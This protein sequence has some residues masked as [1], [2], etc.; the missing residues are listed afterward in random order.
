MRVPYSWLAEL[1]ELPQNIDDL[2]ARLTETGTEVE[3]LEKTGAEFDHIVT[4]KIVS[5]EKH[6]DSDHMWVTMVDLGQDEPVQIVCGAQNFEEGDHIVTAL[7]GAHLPGDIVIKKSKLRGVV[8][9]GMNCSAR[10]LGL[11]DDHDGIMILPE[12]A[13]IGLPFAQYAK[14]SDTI[15]VLEPTPNRPDM[16]SMYGTAR[17]VG[18]I[19]DKPFGIEARDLHESDELSTSDKVAVSIQDP[20][21]AYRYNARLITDV[22]VGPSPEWLQDKI[23][24][25][26][27]RPI[28]NVVDLTN[29]IMF[30]LGQPLHAFDFDTLAKNAQGKVEIEVRA[31]QD[32]EKFTT[33]DQVERKLTE[34]MTV[35]SDKVS[36]KAIALAG[37]MGGLNSEVSE[38][39]TAVLL[40]TAA[41]SSAYTSRTSRNLQ[42]FSEASMRF[43]RQVDPNQVSWIADYA[44]SLLAEISGGKIAKGAVEAVA[45]EFTMPKL[46]LRMDKLRSFVGAPISDEEG[47]KFLELL[48]C[49]VNHEASEASKYEV[50]PPSFRPDLEREIDLYEE[51]LR[52]WG[53]ERVESKLP[54][55]RNHAGGLDQ[56][57]KL[58][59]KIGQ[60]LRA[61]GLSE[62]IT[63]SLVDANDLVQLNMSEV[64]L[65]LAT[66]LLNPMS[67]EQSEMRRSL[68]P[69]LLRA[70]AYN[71][72]HGVSNVH[73]YEQGTLFFAEEGKKQ[74]KE[75][76]FVSAV[77]CGQWQDDTWMGKEDALG[78]YDAKGIVEVL[79]QELHL[80]K[81]KIA[82][83]DPDRY[84]HLQPGRIA[85]LISQGQVIGWLGEIH[86]RSLKNFEVKGPVAAFELN[87]EFLINKAVELVEYK[88]VPKLPAVEVDFAIVVDEAVTAERVQQVISSSGGKLLE[89]SQLFDVYRDEEKLGADKKSFAFKLRFRSL[90]HTLSQ[91]EVD[92]ALRKVIDKVSRATG[93]EMRA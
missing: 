22:T 34:D 63:Y 79:A 9:H 36:N 82:K 88:D 54:A 40:E 27:A 11:S 53:M 84:P 7:P 20:K 8:S 64:G 71:Q 1:V 61:L 68:I 52:L 83:G 13:P 87:Q 46:T 91:D 65:G 62:T 76:N 59:K 70:I 55:A 92:K 66:K 47:I 74:P 57:Q 43:E 38:N 10:E 78:F 41:F 18:A 75:Q 37:V 19:L 14:L 33:L 67:Q 16:L 6:P 28:N 69:G 44:A 21:R 90:D 17:E 81:V 4:G 58:E 3:E 35:I 60:L 29:Y 15:M 42:L 85:E 50:Q 77:L 31:A 2:V 32:G 49:T 80:K 73:L 89:S 24:K 86:P 30:L 45:Q 25:A 72:A 48:G 93:G 51:I 56:K 12:D 23:R 5:K 26:G 39:T